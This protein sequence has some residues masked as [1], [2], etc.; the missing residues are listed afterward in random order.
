MSSVTF[1]HHKKG[2]IPVHDL[3][4]LL[5]DT[6]THLDH[7]PG[8]DPIQ[9]IVRAA[10]VGV[11][12]ICTVHEITSDEPL[13]A[14]CKKL[15]RW[16]QVDERVA[17]RLIA[18]CHPHEARHFDDEARKKLRFLIDQGL[19][20]ALGEMGLDYYYDL[21]DR[22]V[23]RQVFIEQLVLAHETGL[24][25]D[26]HIRDAHDDAYQILKAYGVPQAGCVLHCFTLNA[27]E[28]Q[29]FKEIGC[30]FSIGGALTFAKLDEL[31]EAVSIHQDAIIMTETDA[32]YM[33][34]VPMRGHTCEV[35]MVNLTAHA[36]EQ[37][38][39]PDFMNRAYLHACRI[40]GAHA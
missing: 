35:A 24:P 11:R 21:S 12:L 33:A 20:A 19:V 31:R 2:A 26:L 39:S 23:Q 29:R 8:I 3:P 10:Q 15:E 36:M 7:E 6:H 17:I 30:A 1:T 16:Q 28:M 37:L 32:P 4:Y 25:V 9:Q 27:A 14:Y 13:S 40:F 34:P 18:G 22:E 38:T 5:A